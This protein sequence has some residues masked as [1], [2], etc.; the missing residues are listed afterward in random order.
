MD[1]GKEARTESLA[2]RSE[3][4]DQQEERERRGI[5]EE[6]SEEAESAGD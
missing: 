2:C 4:G 6:R 5:T 3:P 1:S